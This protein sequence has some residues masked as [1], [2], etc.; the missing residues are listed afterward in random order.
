M[1][2]VIWKAKRNLVAYPINFSISSGLGLGCFGDNVRKMY[3]E[4]SMACHQLEGID[5]NDILSII[6]DFV[7]KRLKL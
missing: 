2:A 1:H 4:C 5:R 7:L 3:Q 6:R